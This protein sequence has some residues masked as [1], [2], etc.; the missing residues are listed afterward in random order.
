MTVIGRIKS[1]E[2][3]ENKFNLVHGQIALYWN[4]SIVFQQLVKEI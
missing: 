1:A 4:Y 3:N 2:K